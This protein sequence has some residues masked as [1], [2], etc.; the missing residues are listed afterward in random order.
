MWWWLHDRPEVE[1]PIETRN[2]KAGCRLTSLSSV[3]GQSSVFLRWLHTS[4]KKQT[5]SCRPHEVEAPLCL[6]AFCMVTWPMRFAFMEVTSTGIALGSLVIDL[7]SLLQ[8]VSDTTSKCKPGNPNV[9]CSQFEYS[10]SL[11]G[12]TK[13]LS[14]K[15]ELE[16][17]MSPPRA[18][19]TAG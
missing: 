3:A 5:K 18:L 7:L 9:G 2:E 11:G 10:I 13:G 14:I 15:R 8:M 19:S 6:L 17:V 12:K 4:R 16:K 1:N